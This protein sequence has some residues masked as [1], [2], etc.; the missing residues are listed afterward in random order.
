[1]NQFTQW[2]A[3]MPRQASPLDRDFSKDANSPILYFFIRL[4]RVDEQRRWHG[5]KI[6]PDEGFGQ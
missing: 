5:I 4:K 1:M 6:V 3:R 2:L